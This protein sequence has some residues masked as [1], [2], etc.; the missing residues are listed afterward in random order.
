MGTV[1][2]PD[3]ALKVFLTASADERAKRRYNQLKEKGLDASLAD[4]VREI[5]ERDERDSNRS[6]APLVAAPDALQLES[7]SLS[8]DE[9]LERVLD[10]VRI[11]FPALPV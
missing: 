2:F 7:T 5:R 9:V 3:A 4:L 10:Q 6:V 8:I 1:V 11:T